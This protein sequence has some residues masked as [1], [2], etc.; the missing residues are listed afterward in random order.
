MTISYLP[1]VYTPYIDRTLRL[2]EYYIEECQCELCDY[3]R[4]VG[5]AEMQQLNR[6]F[7]E[8]DEE[9]EKRRYIFKRLLYQYGSDRPLGF[10]DQMSRLKRPVTIDI[11]KKQVRHGYLAHSY[12]LNYLSSH[13]HKY[14][15]LTSV[16]NKLQEEFAYFNWTTDDNENRIRRFFDILQSFIPC[17]QDS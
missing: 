13:E 14:D 7:E 4:N 16:I 9:E 11:F 17:I 15:K 10:I 1:S 3:D 8:N 12:I 2:R 6:Q 5:R